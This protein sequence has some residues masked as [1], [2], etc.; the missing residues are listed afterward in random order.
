MFLMIIIETSK[1][2]LLLFYVT[3]KMIKKSNNILNNCV[4]ISAFIYN[5]IPLKKDKLN[6]VNS[7][8][9]IENFNVELDHFVCFEK[10]NNIR[11]INKFIIQVNNKLNVD[12]YFIGCGETYS[13]RRERSIFS[14]IP[15]I[16]KFI[17]FIQ[18]IF[19]RVFPKIWGL[20]KIYFFIT[21]GRNRLLSKAEILGRLVSCG[22]EIIDYKTINGILYF[23]TKKKKKPIITNV[24]PSYGPIY[25]MPRIGKNGKIIGVYKFR[26]MHPYAEFLQDYIINKNGY[27]ETGKPADDFRLTPWGRFFRK[28]WIDE[29]PQL[30]NVLKGELKIV[31]VRPISKRFFDDIPKDLQELRIKHKPGCIPPYVSLNKTGSVHDVLNAERQYLIEKNNNPYFTDLKYFIKA[32]YNILVKRK[33]S[34]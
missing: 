23:I 28:Y 29:T 19:L 4:E 25:K 22:F 20:K 32:I 26:T 15:F 3:E 7:S 16:K 1:I 6:F 2:P 17:F 21:K 13:S 31:G 27:S 34:A 10:L 9:E 11:Y 12:S 24:K 8:I 18:F 5:Y 30:L 14:K 33:R